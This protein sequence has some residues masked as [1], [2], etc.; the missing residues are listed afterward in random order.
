M[1]D[2]KEE[3]RCHICGGKIDI[4]KS[5]VTGYW[6]GFCENGTLCKSWWYNTE[7]YDTE[8]QAYKAYVDRCNLN[9]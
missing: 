7:G 1:S 9:N 5:K 2:T 4:E 6:K 8:E 3:L